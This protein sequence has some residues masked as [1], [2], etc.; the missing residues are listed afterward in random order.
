MIFMSCCYSLL[1]ELVLLRARITFQ[2]L[3]SSARYSPFSLSTF[4]AA[5]PFPAGVIYCYFL[6]QKKCMHGI[7][8]NVLSRPSGNPFSRHAAA[9]SCTSSLP[10]RAHSG[11]QWQEA[12]DDV[13]PAVGFN[14]I[15]HE[16]FSLFSSMHLLF[17][18]SCEVV[19][20]P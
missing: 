1:S 13:G 18:F 3:T 8:W 9:S 6:I 4:P 12:G 16:A 17:V 7:R 14:F 15:F 11:S 19:I 2:L 10:A 20:H 5:F